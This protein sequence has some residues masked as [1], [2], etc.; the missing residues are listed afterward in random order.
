M[1]VQE[2]S[3][4][5]QTIPSSE[6]ITTLQNCLLHLC[7]AQFIFWSWSCSRQCRVWKPLP[8][9][10]PIYHE[11][12]SG[13]SPAGACLLLTLF[14]FVKPEKFSYCPWPWLFSFF[15]YNISTS[16]SFQSVLFT[17]FLQSWTQ[18]AT[19]DEFSLSFLFCNTR[20]C[21]VLGSTV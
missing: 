5:H 4:W 20:K 12:S 8:I 15:Y 13:L 7:I 21:N 18:W 2:T 16:D 19:A 6:C 11:T 9:K 10:P 17:S 3:M 14:C 1:P